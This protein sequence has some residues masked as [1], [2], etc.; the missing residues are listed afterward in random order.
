MPPET[1]HKATIKALKTGIC[2]PRINPKR[3][4]TP[5][6]LPNA[7]LRLANPVGLAAGFDKNADVFTAMSHFGFGFVECGT[8]TPRPQEGNARPRLFRLSEDKAVINRMGFNNEGLEVFTAR[9]RHAA[10]AS[11]PVGANVGANKDSEDRIGDYET[12]IAAVYP[13]AGYI[14]I[15]ISSPNTPGLHSQSTALFDSL[16]APPV[17][18][19]DQSRYQATVR[20]LESLVRRLLS[21]AQRLERDLRPW[22]SYLILPL[23]ALAN[24]GIAVAPSTLD[25]L[26]PVSLGV[27]VGLV[28]GKPLGITLATWLAVRAGLADQPTEFSWR[29][30]AGAGALCGIGFTMSIFIADAAFA[31]SGPLAL[32]KVSVMVACVLAAGLGWWLLRGA[33]S[34]SA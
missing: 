29:Q 31:D 30:V 10:R 25:F 17:A 19:N 8:V 28:I 4:N 22:S 14:T 20:A 33:P 12:G 18:S 11:S 13:Y 9:L 26:R 21:P 34:P 15:N 24:A 1:A 7:K 2:V 16:Q 6:T 3:W 23:F 32:A 5:V 27:I